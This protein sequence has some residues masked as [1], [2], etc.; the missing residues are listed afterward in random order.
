V[1]DILP[2]VYSGWPP[3]VDGL[4]EPR[5][6][7]DIFSPPAPST[8]SSLFASLPK[9]SF[10]EGFSLLQNF[11]AAATRIAACSVI[12]QAY[13]IPFTVKPHPSGQLRSHACAIAVSKAGRTLES[14]LRIGPANAARP[15][16]GCANKCDPT[17]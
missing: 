11:V 17:R 6:P 14:N 13:R 9:R 5:R 1:E 2:P 7:D 8:E 10:W 4:K 12:G 15:A 3:K 16:I